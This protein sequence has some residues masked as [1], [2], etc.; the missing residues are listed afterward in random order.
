[1]TFLFTDLEGSTRLWDQHPD[2]MRVALARHDEILRTAVEAQGGSVFFDGGDGLG[3]VFHR[4][5]DADNVA[6]EAQRRLSAEP[7]PA[8][9]CLRV[10][11]GVHTGE[12]QERDGNYF[13]RAVNRAARV[14][15]VGHGGQ[16]L[17]SGATSAVLAGV[18]LWD[19]GVYRLRDLS[20]TERLF[21]VRAEGLAVE[22][23]RLRTMDAA[24]GNLPQQMTSFV[25]RDVEVAELVGLMR[26]NRMVTLTGVGGVGKTRL[27]VQVAAELVADFPDGLWLVELAPVG[28]PAAVPAVVASAL[29]LTPQA[30]T[31]V[32]DSIAQAVSGRRLLLILD[33]C[34]HVLDA[35]A[36]LVETVLARAATVKL[37][38]TSRE[39]LR[40][41]AEHLWPVPSLDVRAGAKSAAV[42]LF[43]ERA[44]TV[45]PRFEGT[46]DAQ[47]DAVT[48]IC[49]RLDGIALAIELAAA[50]MV[51]MSVQ[52]VR[53]RLDDRFRLLSGSRRGLER[54]QTLRHAVQWSYD[55]LDGDERAVLDRCSVFAGGFDL[56]AAVYACEGGLDEYAVLDV[57][58]SLVRK[59]LV[60][61][62]QTQ[63]HARFGMLETIRQFA[64]DRLAATGTIV[65]VRDRHAR[66]FADQALSY[67]DIWDGPRQRVAVDWVDVEFANLRAG[68]RWAA[69]N[70]DLATATAIAAHTSLLAIALQRF[71]PFGWA[72]EI[73]AAPAAADLRQLP[74]LYTAASI[75]SF[76]GR[77]EEGLGYAERAVALEADPRYDPLE[78]GWSGLLEGLAHLWA[79]RIDRF[80]EICAVLATQPGSARVIGT[81]GFAW[82]LPT[83]GRAEEARTIADEAV[84]AARVL[85]NPF[86]IANVLDG[87]GR[88]FAETDPDRALTVLREGLVFARQHRLPLWEASLAQDAA[89]LEAMHGELEQAL[90]LFDSAIDDYHRLGNVAGLGFTFTNLAVFFERLERPEIAA[91][92]YGASTQ[93]GSGIISVVEFA[94]VEDHLRSQLGDAGF[95]KC[96]A[97]GV[98]MELADA[99]LYARRQIQLARRSHGTA[100]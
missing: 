11:M 77:S 34:E 92:V 21:Q 60:V 8:P 12:A 95:D 18:D 37:L 29:G 87:Y 52:D 39:G 91:T 4:A 76:T 7:W 65:Q 54:H 66:Y 80:L 78:P 89:R 27:A 49:R 42:E 90:A 100:T 3:A 9:V 71:E 86:W 30:A 64:E 93:Y 48:E 98:A 15:A 10:R 72:E 47:I 43:V 41:G 46:E 57:L 88:A 14:M 55:L 40:L 58:D 74:R 45:N 61:A 56:A 68:F 44:R 53:D 79:G 5:S 70:G 2:A 96:M 26:A 59:S 62:E 20:G 81:S 94:R 63:D 23:P 6:T 67:W 69:D 85:G 84:A 1:M 50:R 83:V 25:G 82:G 73:L 31:T 28:E 97:D 33:N 51:S 17:V 75:C 13:G 35:A 36:D 38:A 99:V 24:P 19:L 16:I 22:F 32:T